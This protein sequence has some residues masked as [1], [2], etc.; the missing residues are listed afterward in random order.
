MEMRPDAAIVGQVGVIP[1]YLARLALMAY[2]SP[3]F[4]IVLVVG[5]VGM[6]ALKI[7]KPLERVNSSDPSLLC[8]ARHL[9]EVAGCFGSG[10]SGVAI[11]VHLGEPVRTR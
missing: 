9:D 6:L 7:W 5:L 4:L 2:L 11:D 3:V 10:A 1:S 8:S